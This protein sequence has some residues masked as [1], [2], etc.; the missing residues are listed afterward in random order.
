MGI[1]LHPVERRNMALH[2]VTRINLRA[3]SL[4]HS[5]SPPRQNLRAIPPHTLQ[6]S[7]PMERMPLRQLHQVLRDP[8]THRHHT[9]DRPRTHLRCQHQRPQPTHL[10]IAPLHNLNSSLNLAVAERIG[11]QLT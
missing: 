9:P 10:R 3:S 7:L 4:R 6:T 2:Q 5:P 11:P 8:R 1:R